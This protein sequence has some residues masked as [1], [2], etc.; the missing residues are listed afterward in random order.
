M[1]V[2]WT[3]IA[4]FLFAPFCLIPFARAEEPLVLSRLLDKVRIEFPLILA[5]EED[6]NIA[7]GQRLNALGEFDVR[8]KTRSMVV[9]PGYYDRYVLDSL[10]EK[11]TSLGGL[12]IY[13]GYRQGLGDFAVYDEKAKTMDGGEGRLGFALPLMRDSAIDARRAGLAI[14]DIGIGI[15]DQTVQTKKIEI[16]LKASSAYWK[17]IAAGRKLTI[18]GNLLKI[19]KERDRGL[20]E[21]V[22]HGDI[23]EFERKD[24]LRGLLFRENQLFAAE[25]LFQEAS[26]EL[27][28]YFRDSDGQPKLPG[29]ELLPQMIP[30]IQ[31]KS[32]YVEEK[33]V[34]RAKEKRPELTRLRQEHEQA[35][36][37]GRHADNQL[38]PKLDLLLEVSKETGGT[39][40]TRSPTELGS[41][42]QIEV[43]LQR[44][45]AEGKLAEAQAKQRKL[46]LEL[47]YMNQRVTADIQ[48]AI[49]A[50]T[51]SREQLT[52][53]SKELGYAR[54]LEEGERIR[55]EAGESTILIVNLR[56]Q[57]TAD[58]AIR[59]VDA[60]VHYH[61]AEA[62]L[63]AALGES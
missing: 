11:P 8:W 38:L 33:L 10:V 25:R 56:E 44:R 54:E 3:T 49:S 60:L 26:F 24:N 61:L 58:S 39:D 12:D 37:S 1:R 48:D 21:R 36:I 13:G 32:P 50:L 29:K 18:V 55:F 46:E 57:A 2:Y 4:A 47:Q 62:F 5:A 19:A 27:S 63:H 45:K 16:I 20:V 51:I 7:Q 14:A 40:P 34:A 23:A 59:Q 53:V 42:V 31:A 22:A 28:L 15:A 43:P 41:G 9:S 30:P 6:R 52:V 17:W 35:A